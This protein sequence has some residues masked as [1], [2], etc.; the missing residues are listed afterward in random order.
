MQQVQTLFNF[1]FTLGF[2]FICNAALAKPGFIALAKYVIL[3]A[4]S[5]QQQ[6]Q[7]LEPLTPEQYEQQRFKRIVVSHAL[8]VP[9]VPQPNNASLT[10]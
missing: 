10:Q 6:Q 4:L 7:A 9:M 1:I 3:P 8:G 5:T 2:G